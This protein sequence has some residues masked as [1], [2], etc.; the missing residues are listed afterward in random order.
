MMSRDAESGYPWKNWGDGE[1]RKILLV[2]LGSLG[3]VVH[4]APAQQLLIRILPRAEIHWLTEPPYAEFLRHVPGIHR[5]WTADTKAWRR[6]LSSPL[7]I[8]RFVVGLQREGFDAVFD[9]QGL[10]KSAI[11]SRLTGSG[12]VVGFPA[13]R[14]RE[15][16]SRFFYTCK[17]EIQSG[18]RH[19][20]EL[21][22]DLVDPPCSEAPVGSRIPLDIPPAA[23][24]FLDE[25]FEK[26]RLTDPVLLNPGAGWPTKRWEVRRWVELAERIVEEL[27]LSVLF[28]HGPGE[29]ALMRKA[30]A[31][32]PKVVKTFPSSILELAALCKR[33][34]LMVAGDTGPMHLAVA[35]GTPVVALIGP[36]RSWRTGP[37][38]PHD[39]VVQ[40]ERLCPHPYKRKCKDHYC[41]DFPVARVFEAVVERLES[42][43]G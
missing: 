20:I 15:R 14:L 18:E 12:C 26:L 11:L 19:Q 23:D 5:V 43:T 13:S 31:A 38:N 30:L 40:H 42:R 16:Q 7:A 8:A 41:M 10:L 1:N 21:N 37:F 35:M 6:K 34:R 4:A 28:T 9:F 32:G 39:I 24:E 17:V 2:R 3:D 36:G 29:E 27:Q 33:S 22:R 25:Q